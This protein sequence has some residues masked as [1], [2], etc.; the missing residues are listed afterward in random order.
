M[1]QKW[2]DDYR[3]EIDQIDTQHKTFFDATHRLYDAIMTAQ[4]EH[5]VEEAL[6]F[7][8]SYAAEHFEAEEGFMQMLE[9]PKLKAHKKLHADFIER[10]GMLTDEY[11]VY[12]APSQGMADQILEVTQDWLIDHIID[13]D[14]LYARYMKDLK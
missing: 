12:R 13:Q 9:Y 5:A 7:L 2:S 6:V 14:T 4:G 10:L 8:C 3:I 1:L 11:D